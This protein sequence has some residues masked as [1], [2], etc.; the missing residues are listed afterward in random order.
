[1]QTRDLY[2]KRGIQ[3]NRQGNYA[4][5]VAAIQK[6]IAIDPNYA[7]AHSNLGIAHTLMK[8]RE[9]AISCFEK[10]LTLDPE[11]PSMYYKLGYAYVE[12]GRFE[13]AKDITTAALAF[14]ENLEKIHYV[15]GR[16]YIGLN[17]YDKALYHFQTAR[18]LASDEDE[19]EIDFDFF[20]G[21]TLVLLGELDSALEHFQKCLA[22]NPGV[23][24][25]HATIALIYLKQGEFEEAERSL[26][27]A[28]LLN[29]TCPSTHHV[30]EKFEEA[31]RE[32]N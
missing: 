13:E 8:N 27:E 30:L 26:S 17:I 24:S 16:T 18:A 25:V 3:H 11:N 32:A 19:E 9:Q 20:I 1:M 2:L 10:A 22:R 23:S 7:E 5:A 12:A 6:A 14:N 4:K 29:P 15:L 31:Q 28:L 21:S